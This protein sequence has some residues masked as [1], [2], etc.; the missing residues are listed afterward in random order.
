MKREIF[1]EVNR[2]DLERY[3]P[4]GHKSTYLWVVKVRTFRG[5]RYV[6]LESKGAYLYNVMNINHVAPTCFY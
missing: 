6:L 4:F 3:V 1:K 2:R 5:E